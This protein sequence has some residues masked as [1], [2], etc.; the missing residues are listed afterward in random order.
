M[1]RRLYPR[2]GL[3]WS[4][5]LL[6]L[7]APSAVF[8]NRPL[9]TEDATVIS[10]GKGQLEMS[11]DFAAE[12]GESRNQVFLVVPGFGIADR[13]EFTLELP[14]VLGQNEGEGWTEGVGDIR[15]TA[16]VL[17]VPERKFVPAVGLQGYF[18]FDTGKKSEGSGTDEREAGF[19]VILSKELGDFV[20]HGMIGLDFETSGSTLG[21]HDVIYGAAIDYTVTKIAGRPFHLVTEVFGNT[22]TNP[23]ISFGP[24]VWFFGAVY[25]LSEAWALDSGIAVGLT[26]T[27]TN[28]NTT[29]GATFVFP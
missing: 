15:A 25:E 12:F 22:D 21:K 9:T 29:L 4:F 24:A 27:G 23:A 20:L 3:R 19:F 8:A 6:F 7:L 26:E 14:F 18:K 28:L 1:T 2:S 11:W 17:L 5:A 13:V 16:K 10:A